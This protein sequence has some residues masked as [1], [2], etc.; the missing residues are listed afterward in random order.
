MWQDAVITA[1]QVGFL[2]ALLPTVFHPE[3]KPAI[4]TSL[5]TALGL[6][7]LAGTFATL[8]LY[9]SAIIA[10]LVGATWSLLAYQRRRLDA[11]KSVLERPHG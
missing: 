11:A 8:S 6:Y 1:V 9:F 3:H 7:I 4:S 10:A 2:F 5:L